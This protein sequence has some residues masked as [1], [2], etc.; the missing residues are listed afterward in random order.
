MTTEK[1]QN[2]MAALALKLMIKKGGTLRLRVS[3]LT[4]MAGHVLTIM[5]NPQNRDVIHLGI[6]TKE[7]SAAQIAGMIEA[8]KNTLKGPDGTETEKP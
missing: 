8:V 7:E 5:P 6:M 3:E 2:S 4:E 1:E